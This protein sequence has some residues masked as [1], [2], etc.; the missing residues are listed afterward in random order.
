M[1]NSID[2][3]GIAVYSIESVKKIFAK[4]FNLTPVFEE[5]VQDQ[6]VKVV[7]FRVGQ[8]TLEFLEPT[9]KDSPIAKFLEKRGEGIHHVSIDVNDI[10]AALKTLK[11]E[12]IGLIDQTPR[13]GAE[14]KKIAFVHPKSLFG[15]LLELSEELEDTNHSP[16][17]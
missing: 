8:S 5:I 15:I 14:G 17:P 1:L 3:L 6:Q 12:D 4:I 7:G 10:T 2:H 16:S 11:S 9:S 13:V